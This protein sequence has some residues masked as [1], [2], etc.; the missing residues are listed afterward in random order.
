[1]DADCQINEGISGVTKDTRNTRVI[2]AL[3]LSMSAGAF[4]LRMI[5]VPTAGWSRD[6]VLMAER[7]RE[8]DA[9]TIACVPYGEPISRYEYDCVVLPD[10]EIRCD[11][12]AGVKDVYIAVAGSAD[13]EFAR[14]QQA[15]LMRVLGSLTQQHHLDL[16]RVRLHPDSDSRYR[17]D[18]SNQA[19]A[20]RSLL[21]RKGIVQ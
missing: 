3:V 13:G 1:M 19:I 5:A 7:V 20:L 16:T 8:V 4:V 17:S 11:L 2:I 21:V 6:T 9:A 10:G 14:P 15:A 18:L 12:R